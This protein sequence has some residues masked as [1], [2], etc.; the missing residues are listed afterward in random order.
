MERR[1]PILCHAAMDQKREAGVEKGTWL[2]YKLLIFRR[3]L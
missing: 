2:E 3:S 1:K